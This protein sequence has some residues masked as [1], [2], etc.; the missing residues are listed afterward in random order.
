MSMERRLFLAAGLAAVVGGCTRNTRDGMVLDPATGRMYGMRSDG[1]PVFTDSSLFPNR[2]LKLSMRNMSGD[3]VWD[4][5]PTRERLHQVFLDKGYQRSDGTDFGLKVD[6]NVLRSQQFDSSMLNDYALLGGAAGVVPGGGVGAGVAGPAGIVG[7]GAAGMAA[8]A[9]LGAIAGYFTV[10]SIYV[11]ITEAVF[12]VRRD[13]TRPRRVVTFEGS[14]RIEEWEE[15][16]YDAFRKVQR[17][18]IAN[19]GGGRGVAQKE[20]AADIRERQIRSLSGFL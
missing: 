2:R 13:S 15:R 19:Y 17:V 14:P 7:G 1:V 20:I 6:L 10:D 12:G 8:G 4:L 16:G 3:A 5:E 9:S 18:L 11:V